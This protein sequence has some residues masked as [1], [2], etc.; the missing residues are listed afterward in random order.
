MLPHPFKTDTWVEGERSNHA[1]LCN[2]I[3]LPQSGSDICVLGMKPSMLKYIALNNQIHQHQVHGR[4]WN[5]I[6]DPNLKMLFSSYSGSTPDQRMDPEAVMDLARELYDE[7]EEDLTELYNNLGS[8][9]TIR[10]IEQLERLKLFGSLAINQNFK[11]QGIMQ[12][13]TEQI[14]KLTQAQPHGLRRGELAMISST[15]NTGKSSDT[16]ELI[17]LLEEAVPAVDNIG[18]AGTQGD[19]GEHAPKLQSFD[20]P[21][22]VKRKKSKP[23]SNHLPNMRNARTKRVL[24]ATILN[25]LGKV[26]QDT[27]DSYKRSLL[28]E[29]PLAD[30]VELASGE[31]LPDYQANLLNAM[32]AKADPTAPIVERVNAGTGIGLDIIQKA[33]DGSVATDERLIAN[34]QFVEALYPGTLEREANVGRGLTAH[35]LTFDDA[36]E[37][38]SNEERLAIFE[39]NVDEALVKYIS[40]ELFPEE[41]SEEKRTEIIAL[42]KADVMERNSSIDR[43]SIVTTAMSILHPLDPIAG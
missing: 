30:F 15:A 39:K 41:L 31:K 21:S 20:K 4:V 29:I 18:P 14:A 13:T 37:Q 32:Q 11:E 1:N 38:L 25:M 36:P 12:S 22:K 23:K 2:E 8:L 7:H 35:V 27:Q 5:L 16:D 42:V 24:G 17:R 9:R 26:Q 34:D 19:R 10:A 43:Q 6:G 40:P 3:D 28:K 33:F